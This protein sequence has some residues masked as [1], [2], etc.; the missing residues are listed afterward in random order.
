[1]IDHTLSWEVARVGGMIAYL[2]VTASVAVGM[3]ASLKLRSP[4][5][6]R[7]VTTELHRYT[8]VLALVFSA[9]H[10]LAV[11][12]DP[13]TGFSPGEV[14]VPF[15][16][17]YR[18]LWVALGI[19]SGYLLLSVWASEYVRGRIGYAWW[20][21]LHFSAFG[22]FSLASLHG[23]ATGSDTASPWGLALYTLSVGVV[24]VL[25]VWRLLAGGDT[26][27]RAVGIVASGAVVGWLV[28]FTLTGPALAGWNT[29]ANS[30]NGSGASDAWLAAHPPA[31]APAASFGADLVVA[32]AAEDR[33]VA[34]FAG[35]DTGSIAVR[36]EEEG[37]AELS[38][39]L[40]N[41]WGCSGTAAAT[42]SG[43]SSVCRAGDGRTV[44]VLVS[45]L[46]RTDDGGIVGHIAV[47]AAAP[48]G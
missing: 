32:I 4:R 33:L 29:I 37:T 46:R 1:M 18:P 17:H 27:G 26:I 42:G 7:F 8:T 10:G 47:E 11:W 40:S 21:R 5:W 30:D 14:F 38:L 15:A 3:L 16:S 23:I 34:H 43:I 36:I 44:V 28:V 45:A 31:A 9:I 25:V 6:P 24:L 48:Q 13:F 2:L 19:V 22:V 35:G 20:R 12:L 39:S 41:G